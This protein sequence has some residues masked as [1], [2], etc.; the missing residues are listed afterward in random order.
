MVRLR[1]PPMP[2]GGLLF[3]GRVN[4]EF[5]ALDQATGQTL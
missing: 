5:I 1:T 3:T 4:G 2:D